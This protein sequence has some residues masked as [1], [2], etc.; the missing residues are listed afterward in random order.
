MVIDDL[1]DGGPRR[2]VQLELEEIDGLRRADVVVDAA[3][4]RSGLCSDA[5]PEQPEDAEEDGLV[6][7][8]K[9]CLGLKILTWSTRFMQGK[10]IL[11]TLSFIGE[12]YAS[13]ILINVSGNKI[14]LAC[15]WTFEW[16]DENT[17]EKRKSVLMEVLLTTEDSRSLF[18]TFGV[19]SL[20]T[21]FA[22][23]VGMK[24]GWSEATVTSSRIP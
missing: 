7:Y 20:W 2:P 14:L 6:V 1:S 11:H 8:I 13:S 3:L 15:R 24:R 16:D 9:R 12:S 10:M 23:V 18:P 17:L 4:V 21:A 19:R 5:C 22:R